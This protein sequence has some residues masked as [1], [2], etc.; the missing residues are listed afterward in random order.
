MTISTVLS[1]DSLPVESY[2][3]VIT[4]MIGAREIR[5][6]L[7]PVVLT[8]T[9]KSCHYYI[10]VMTVTLRSHDL[11]LGFLVMGDTPVAL[12]CFFRINLWLI[13]AEMAGQG[14]E[15]FVLG[16]GKKEG[17]ERREG[18]GREGGREGGGNERR[19]SVRKGTMSVG[20]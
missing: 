8:I 1:A 19:E 17:E 12:C 16:K 20:K 4:G 18:G 13:L 5:I 3:T 11:T 7:T 6:S 10:Q 15:P 14:R 2:L 9:H